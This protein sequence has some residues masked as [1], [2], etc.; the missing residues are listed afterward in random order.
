[1]SRTRTLPPKI[2]NVVIV[3]QENHTFDNYFGIYP[4]SDGIIG[5]EI[6]LPET[7]GSSSP[8]VSP[9]HETSL[10]PVDM[11]HNWKSAH[12]D[13][14]G[15]KMG[16]FV[17]S[18]GSKETM[19][20]YERADIQRY[21]KAADNYTLCDKYF[22]SVMSESAPNHLFLVA[23]TSGGIIDDNVPATLNFPPIF[24]QLDQKA[25]SWKVYGFTKWYESFDYIRMNPTKKVS[26]FASSHSFSSDLKNGDL[27]QVSWI[28]GA[29]GGD[30][31]PP[32]NIQAG[33]N[34]VADDIV[35]GIGASEYWNSVAVFV[36]WDDYGGFYDH[37][38]PPQVDQF[39]YGFRV[40]CLIISPY[41]RV[42]FLDNVVNDHTSILRFVEDNWALSP[43]SSRDSNANNL[44]EAFDF[45][46]PA[47]SFIPI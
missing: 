18:E 19:A 22:T 30:E 35:N 41:S 43:L 11:N 32:A 31:H 6:C 40:P 13:Y 3:L 9:F 34:S 38:V 24:Q 46:K 12:A 8:C 27:A 47:R 26:N 15:G 2:K 45:T 37:V 14:N 28:V 23:G 39:G 36:T 25:I 42:G 4:G 5:K 10:T 16:G 1:M 33:E 20:Y 29:P 21:Y 44:L 7:K 17:Y